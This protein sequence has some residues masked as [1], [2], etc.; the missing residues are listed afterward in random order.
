MEMQIQLEMNANKRIKS[1]SVFSSMYGCACVCMCVYHAISTHS[2]IDGWAFFGFAEERVVGVTAPQ[3]FAWV[4][5]PVLK[6]TKQ[7]TQAYLVLPSTSAVTHIM[8]CRVQ[9]MLNMVSVY[10]MPYMV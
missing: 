10:S 6:R 9:Y 7:N 2:P 4:K 3:L 5:W 8:P 1:I